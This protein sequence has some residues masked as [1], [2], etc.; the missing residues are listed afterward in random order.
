MEKR[1]AF[2]LI[3]L[4]VV[5]SIIAVLMS[6]M[7][8]ALGKVRKQA[9]AV[10]CLTNLKQIGTSLVM[11]ETDY[12]N[13]R[14]EVSVSDAE[15][16]H[17]YGLLATYLG[18]D[19]AK[20]KSDVWSCP[21]ASKLRIDGDPAPAQTG[22]AYY[23][24]KTHTGLN[25]IGSY[26]INGWIVYSDFYS[27]QYVDSAKEYKNFTMVTND[28]PLF[29]DAIWENGW[30]RDTDIAPTEEELLTGDEQDWDNQ[31]QRFTIDRHQMKINLVFGDGHA[32]AVALSKLWSLPWHRGFDKQSDVEVPRESGSTSPRR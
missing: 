9:K 2:T 19:Q 13:K 10:T 23:A 11:Y 27:S 24:Y 26:G 18:T 22:Q 8:P 1:K 12:Q 25:E 7:M 30:F 4:L 29:A 28:V 20:E 5:I 14:I 31:A 32:E 3:E 21:S 6:I 15:S 16:G 17:I